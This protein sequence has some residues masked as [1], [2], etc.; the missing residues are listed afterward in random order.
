MRIKI[1]LNQN[2]A[3]K[4]ASVQGIEVARGAG[5]NFRM[6]TSTG[7]SPR[8]FYGFF[9]EAVM[10]DTEL[11]AD[12][13][14]WKFFGQDEHIQFSGSP[15]AE[16]ARWLAT[17][18]VSSALIDRMN[19]WLPVSR[20]HPMS[21]QTEIRREFLDRMGIPDEM[22][23]SPVSFR[24]SGKITYE[25]CIR[26]QCPDGKVDLCVLGA[27]ENG[28]T[29]FN[30]PG[31]RRTDVTRN[32]RLTRSTIDANH[33]FLHGTGEP[34]TPFFA[35]TIGPS[36]TIDLSKEIIVLIFG[37]KKAAAAKAGLEGPISPNCPLSFVREHPNVT[38]YMDIQAAQQLSFYEKAAAKVQT[39]S[40]CFSIE[41]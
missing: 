18:V 38:V 3:S 35:R 23:F 36:T 19:L 41:L 37:P 14:Y 13:A 7:S 29:G 11:Q 31:S 21:Y 30:E 24:P 9:S 12:K 8:P 39:E 6:I 10:T 16:K 1:H 34:F 5:M 25:G 22:I 27:G 32:V 33:R 20:E 28:H 4:H 26:N 17:G 15:W 2:T 40:D